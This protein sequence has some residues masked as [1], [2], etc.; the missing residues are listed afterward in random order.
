MMEGSFLSKLVRGD[1]QALARCISL[2]ENE[3]E[4]Y[5]RILE[6]LTFSSSTIMVGITGPPGAG[7]STL[8]DG[9]TQ[10]LLDQQKKVAI[11]AVDPS[12]PFH[13]GA[14]LGDRVRMSRHFTDP[15]VFIRSLSSRGS[16]GGLHPKILEIADLIRAAGFDY[17]L[18]ETVGVGQSEVEIASLA[19]T[20]VVVLVPESG[21]EVQTMKAGLLEIADLLVV[22]K[23][24]RPDA[25]ALIQGLKDLSHQNSGPLWEIPVLKT[26]AT[27][28]EGISGLMEKINMHQALLD[29][30]PE[31][32][33][34]LLAE[35]AFQLIQ[36]GRMK[37]MDKKKLQQDILSQLESGDFNMYRW[38]Q[39]WK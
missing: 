7:K 13:R 1:S 14:L 8:V 33:S 10:L 17:L 34:M 26:I 35:K 29:R 32:K 39:Q 24:E 2:V 12:S 36:A 37:D 22:N 28:G 9:M 15:R 21:D 5:A 18:I 25:E 16:L 20:T 23:A 30:D 6:D 31:K 38:I 11:L 19:D 4:G 3:V 27:S